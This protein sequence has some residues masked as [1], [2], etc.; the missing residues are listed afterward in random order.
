MAQTTQ[1]LV[2]RAREQIT[3]VDQADA[4][5]RMEHGAV[6]LDVRDDHEYDAGHVPDAVHI[7]RGCLEFKIG[8]NPATKDPDTE[9][10]V[11]CKGG[12]RAA[13]AAQ[14]LQEMGYT[15]VVS[16]KG[17]YD[18][19]VAAGEDVATEGQDEEE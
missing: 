2:A 7:T 14:R 1:D 18:G 12:G 6:V 3:E 13:M 11:Y 16:M 19:W 8:D 5:R 4:R 17:G 9:I 10:V 15:N